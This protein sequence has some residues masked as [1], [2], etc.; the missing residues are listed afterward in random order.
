MKTK[1]CSKCGKTKSV[2]EFR[3]DKNHSSGYSSWCKQC[4]N[5][6]TA[7]WAVTPSGIYSSSKFHIRN[8]KPFTM[9]RKEFIEWYNRQEKRCVYCDLLEEDMSK[10]DDAQLN[11]TRRLTIDCKENDVGYTI[12]NIVLS[13]LRCNFMKNDFL[14]FDD[15]REIGQKYVK[16]IWEKR[17]GKK[18]L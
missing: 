7:K 18:L 11:R 15:M 3:I 6:A 17:L 5:E 10:I 12:D 14:D 13:C 9:K 16:P 1:Q 8:N 2:S 4:S